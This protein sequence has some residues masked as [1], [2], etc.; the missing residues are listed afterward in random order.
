MVLLYLSELW[1]SARSICILTLVPSMPPLTC[2]SLDTPT[3]RTPHT[4]A[5]HATLLHA[6]PH[7]TKVLISNHLHSVLDTMLVKLLDP[8][9]HVVMKA[10][11]LDEVSNN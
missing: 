6:T 5:H 9:V 8:T 11:L 7:H 2:T 3:P 1:P 4:R 10:D